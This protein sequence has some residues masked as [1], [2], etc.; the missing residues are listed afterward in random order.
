MTERSDHPHISQ[1]IAALREAIRRE[2]GHGPFHYALAALL[3]MEGNS[4][5]ATLHMEKA[6]ELGIDV[7]TL[8]DWTKRE[9]QGEAR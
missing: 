6:R 5:E 9:S 8:L 2:P 3:A 4:V 1:A 7:R